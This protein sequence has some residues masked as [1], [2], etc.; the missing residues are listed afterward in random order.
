M[1]REFKLM[2]AVTAFAG[3]MSVSGPMPPTGTTMQAVPDEGL[4]PGDSFVVSN[5]DGSECPGGDVTGDT[6]GIREG[7]WS[8]EMEEDGSWAV[9]IVI[10]ES[11]RPDAMGNPTPFPPGDYEIHAFCDYTASESAGVGAPAGQTAGKTYDPV[12]VSVVA[13]TQDTTPTSEASTPT[14]A[15]GPAAAPAVVAAPTYTG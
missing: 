6:G 10:P 5:A 3:A 4:E 1:Q 9:T 12:T 15:P 14:T 13:P 2:I 8:A 11:G 7:A